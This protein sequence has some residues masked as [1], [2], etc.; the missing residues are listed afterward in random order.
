MSY[1]GIQEVG[2]PQPLDQAGWDEIDDFCVASVKARCPLAARVNVSLAIW[3]PFSSRTITGMFTGAFDT[4]FTAMPV[5]VPPVLS[6]A[7]M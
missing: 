7:M 5:A 3:V 4:A 2:Y 6:K 1:Y